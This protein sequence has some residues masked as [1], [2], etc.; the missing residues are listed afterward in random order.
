[1]PRN[2]TYC[3]Q[4]LPDLD[5]STALQRTNAIEVLSNTAQIQAVR[6]KVAGVTGIVFFSEG[7]LNLEGN[8]FIRVS[9]PCIVMF[10]GQ[11]N[12]LY[13]A[14]PSQATKEIHIE[15]NGQILFTELSRGRTV[16]LPINS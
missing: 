2:A 10:S 13:V 15:L 16:I 9:A 5:L 6:D 7:M 8:S 3:Y 12:R 11:E 14:D 4:I 1:M